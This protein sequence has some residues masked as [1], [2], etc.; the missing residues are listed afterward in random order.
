MDIQDAIV[1]F[2]ILASDLDTFS[3]LVLAK[4]DGSVLPILFVKLN[5]L[6]FLL[7]CQI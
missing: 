5:I 7:I 1:K 3:Q 6:S 2:M 4:V